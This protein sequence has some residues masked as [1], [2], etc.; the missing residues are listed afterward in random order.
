MRKSLFGVISMLTLVFFFGIHLKVGNTAEKAPYVIGT[1][2]ALT[3]H[4][5][6]LGVDAK[7]AEDMAVEEINAAGG[8]NGRL[9]KLISYDDESQPPRSA[10]LVR[11]LRDQGV[12]AIVGGQGFPL[13]RA[14]SQA[15]D[16]VK[17]SFFP[18][19]PVSLP[20]ENGHP[21]NYVFGP[22]LYEW[23]FLLTCWVK[24]LVKDGGPKLAELET[25]DPLGEFHHK[26]LMALKEKSPGIFDVVGSEWMLTTDF[27]M[28]PQLTKLKA[29]KPDA[30]LVGPSGRPGTAVY[31]TLDLM[32][33]RIRAITSSANSTLAFIDSVK[34]FSDQ[35]RLNM[36]AVGLRPDTVPDDDPGNVQALRKIVTKFRKETGKILF[37]GALA[38]YDA[39]HCLADVIGKL[40]LDPDKQGVQ[41]M[42][43]KIRDTLETQTYQATLVSIKRTPQDHRGAA[44]YRFY[45]AK[46]EG[47]WFVPLRW[48]EYPSMKEG[49]IVRGQ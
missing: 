49:E 17:V 10:D 4:Y 21:G 33:W 29:L 48:I 35:V 16:E 38:A 11:K 34:G 47:D 43:D 9:L 20:L 46:I 1:I 45:E 28:T 5:A 44:K 26:K 39:I 27:D 7:K 13:G 36:P 22:L 18:K 42:R 8:I 19:S 32:D 37:D 23:D 2:D 25:S 3:G 30:L 24:F 14:S 15:A 6:P 12:L 41:E 31:K 40:N